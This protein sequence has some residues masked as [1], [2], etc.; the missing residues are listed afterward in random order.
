MKEGSRLFLNFICHTR[1]LLF[2]EPF[3]KKGFKYF[4]LKSC[5][6][7]TMG[8]KILNETINSTFHVL[9]EFKKIGCPSP[10]VLGKWQP[11]QSYHY[12]IYR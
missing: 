2:P 8:M 9:I 1:D 3:K 11:I 10:K 5:G 12:S 4:R 7:V 6:I